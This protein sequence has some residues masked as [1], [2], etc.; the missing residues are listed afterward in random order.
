MASQPLDFIAPEGS[1]YITPVHLF[2]KFPFFYI[3]VWRRACVNRKC[4]V[5][6]STDLCIY[7]FDIILYVIFYESHV[8]ATRYIT[9]Y[10][11]Y[12]N[13]FCSRDII[14]NIIRVCMYVNAYEAR[15]H[16]DH[17]RPSVLNHI[18]DTRYHP[19]ETS[20]PATPNES[21]HHR[22]PTPLYFVLR[23]TLTSRVVDQAVARHKS[24][25]ERK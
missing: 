23:R 12:S 19:P 14:Y 4:L 17:A 7:I 13:I 16:I 2:G 18:P 8:D 9:I 11:R 10:F 1:A 3:C 25:T 21:L 24:A 15:S 20:D 5:R 22:Q 6:T